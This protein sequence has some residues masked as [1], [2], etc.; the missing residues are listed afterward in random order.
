VLLANLLSV[1]LND[2][3]GRHKLASNL[4]AS[5]ADL[6][7]VVRSR[8]FDEPLADIPLSRGWRSRAVLP[9]LMALLT[10]ETAIR[11]A[12]PKSLD[13]LELVELE[14]DDD[15]ADEG[16]EGGDEL[17]PVP[18]AADSDATLSEDRSAA[19]PPEPR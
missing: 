7:A 10:G 13:P 11:V 2:F 1:V 16:D 9:E 3:C 12:D 14:D 17:E 4:V 6:K 18:P 8:A 5:G 15:E 19:A